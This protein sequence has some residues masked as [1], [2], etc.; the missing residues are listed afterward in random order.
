MKYNEASEIPV[1]NLFLDDLKVATATLI[2]ER[3]NKKY[4]YEQFKKKYPGLEVYLQ[5]YKTILNSY[6][7]AIEVMKQRIKKIEEA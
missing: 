5:R 4:E 7:L 2:R 1:Q 6:D 3:D